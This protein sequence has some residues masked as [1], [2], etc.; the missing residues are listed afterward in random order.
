M[1][2]VFHVSLP[3]IVSSAALVNSTATT[4]G[5]AH[6]DQPIDLTVRRKRKM[7]KNEIVYKPGEEHEEEDMESEYDREDDQIKEENEVD[8]AKDL[9]AKT[10]AELV[11]IKTTLECSTSAISDSKFEVP[12]KIMK[13]ENTNDTLLA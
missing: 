13:L 4:S 1:I 6:G 3:Q 2:G 9:L 11:D 10:A 12:I 5:G 7:A 8:I